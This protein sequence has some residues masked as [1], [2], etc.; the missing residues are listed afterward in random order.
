MLISS[1]GRI[2][3][4]GASECKLCFATIMLMILMVMKDR[5]RAFIRVNVG[6]I[7]ST[8]AE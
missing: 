8:H 7:K 3:V 6:I 4:A 2:K 1:L 5:R